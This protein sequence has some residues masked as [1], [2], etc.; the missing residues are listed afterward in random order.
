MIP[1]TEVKY[2]KSRRTW[3]TLNGATHDHGDGPHGKMTAQWFALAH[4]APDVHALVWQL[5]KYDDFREEIVTRLVRAGHL[6]VAGHIDDAPGDEGDVH[7]RSAGDICDY[8][9][10]RV[11]TPREYRCNCRDFGTVMSFDLG[12]ICKHSYA[13]HIQALRPTPFDG[14]PVAWSS[15]WDGGTEADEKIE[16]NF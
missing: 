5:C 6:V 4:D 16:V 8:R 14:A 2:N 7:V 10:S 15:I 13:V 12:P 9:V 1:Q 3:Q 11:G